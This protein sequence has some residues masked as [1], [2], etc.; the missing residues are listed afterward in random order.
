M[1]HSRAQHLGFLIG[2]FLF[3]ATSIAF[4]V[5]FGF[6][7]IT[8]NSVGNA[9]IGEAQLSVDVTNPGAGQV[10]FM[11]SNTGPAAS[12]IAAVYFDD[13]PPQSLLGIASIQNGSG[14]SFSQGASPGNLPGGNNASPAFVTTAGFSAD[15]NPPRQ[16]NGVNPGESLGITFNL[17]GGQTFD[18]VL[19]DLDNGAL[20]IGIHVQGF[21]DGGSESFVN[22]PAPVPEPGTFMLVGTGLV[23]LLGLHR[24]RRGQAA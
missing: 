2:V 21:T 13:G 17:Q 22:T 1:Q 18:D 10:L 11:F 6:D 15:S 20:R 19:T 8:G 9:A 23:S 14:V 24:W 4:A 3:S 7:N 16:P 12:S 5:P